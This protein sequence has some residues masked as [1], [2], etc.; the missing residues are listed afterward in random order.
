MNI[1]IL[2][3]KKQIIINKEM[4]KKTYK[5]LHIY[6][7]ENCKNYK[8]LSILLRPGAKPMRKHDAVEE[9]EEKKEGNV[10]L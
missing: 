8:L 5:K 7:F 6:S 4:G 9:D 3:K 2:K 10:T 1:Y